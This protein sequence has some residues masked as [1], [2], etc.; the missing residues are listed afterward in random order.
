MRMKIQNLTPVCQAK[1]AQL[2]LFIVC[3]HPNEFVGRSH[4]ALMDILNSL[5]LERFDYG[6]TARVGRPSKDRVAMLR[7]F[8]AQKFLKISEMKG[9]IEILRSDRV[10]RNI[11]GWHNVK[12]VPSEATF[13]RFL[14]EISNQEIMDKI[15]ETNK[16]EWLLD[17]YFFHTS[18]DAT[19]L[20]VRGRSGYRPVAKSAKITHKKGRPKIGET[21]PAKELSVIE[22]QRTMTSEAGFSLVKQGLDFGTKR[23]SQGFQETNFG[24]KI[25]AEVAGNGVPV[26]IFISAA[27]VHDSQ[28]AIPLMKKN[29]LIFS[30]GF[31]LMDAGY[32][33]K[34]IREFT[35]L[36][37]I[38]FNHRRNK[39]KDIVQR[40][41]TE[42]EALI[43]NN[44][45]NVERFNSE[46]KKILN[47]KYLNASSL[48]KAKSHV[49]GAVLLI[50]AKYHPK[51]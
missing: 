11:C 13:S 20:A 1:N 39:N 8:I 40:K 51:T 24:V 10:L 35:P 33:D 22:K 6:N 26:N 49:Y 18:I 42:Q 16:N 19:T 37:L 15:Y 45:G 46:I 7:S 2:S 29:S 43:Y 50:F 12:D 30:R 25:H 3:Y 31:H 38:D 28:V 44:R 32:D 47:T 21:R 9:L 36:S 5:E 14:S 27:S 17:K 34:N 41:F 48:A 4:I 23:N